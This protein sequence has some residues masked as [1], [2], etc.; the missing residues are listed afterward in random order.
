LG[1]MKKASERKESMADDVKPDTERNSGPEP[2]EPEEV[3]GED[4]EAEEAE[5][6]E[7]EEEEE[8]VAEAKRGPAAR[9]P[10]PPPP[11]AGGRTG[12]FHVYKPGQ[13]YWTR[14]GTVISA[15]ILLIMIGRFLYTTLAETIVIGRSKLADGTEI[16]KHLPKAWAGGIVGGLMIAAAFWLWRTLNRPSVVDFFIATETEMKK[17]NWTS[18]KDLIG[19][20]KVVIFFMLLIAAALFLIDIAFGY[21]FALVGVLKQGPLT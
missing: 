12:F 3:E 14:L 19:S 1:D 6:T 20:T 16:L 15:V 11:P 2:E 17:V 4:P 5:E 13:G 9:R 18:K 10:A 21:L 8:E 7:A